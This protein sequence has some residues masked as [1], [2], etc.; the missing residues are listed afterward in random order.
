MAVVEEVDE[1]I[2]SNIGPV[3]RLKI[4][5]AAGV[6]V[7]RGV[8]GCGKS[9]TIEAVERLTGD[10]KINP[11]VRDGARKGEI[12]GCGVHVLV[13]RDKSRNHGE[14]VVESLEGKFDF[15]KVVD[16]GGIKNPAAADAYRIKSLLPLKNLTVDEALFYPV[17]GG[18]KAHYDDLAVIASDDIVEHTGRVKRAIEEKARKCEAEADRLWGQHGTR[19]AD[20]AEYGPEIERDAETLNAELERAIAT[21]A[22]MT[23]RAERYH[24][25]HVERDAAKAKLAA[26][27]PSNLAKLQANF[28]AKIEE[29]GKVRIE[30]GRLREKLAALEA[31]EESLT[32]E[33]DSALELRD[34]EKQRCNDRATFEEILAAEIQLGP[35]YEEDFAANDAL[36]AARAAV[37][38]GIKARQADRLAAAAVNI[39]AQ[40]TDYRKRAIQLRDAAKATEE[41]LSDMVAKLGVDLFV[42]E[43]R[44]AM[45][46]DRGV[47]LFADLSQGERS[48]VVMELCCKAIGAGGLIPVAQEFWEG[49]DPINK[50]VIADTARAGGVCVI[51]AEATEGELRAESFAG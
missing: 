26:L 11:D 44:L 18:T 46:T 32:A 38:L 4:P 14:L 37:E 25:Q 45:N 42:Y 9:R 16:G 20:K 31:L 50:K 1:I 43:G 6:T 35:S 41:I 10:K 36:K 30:A 49:Q 51:T 22:A 48:R 29:R 13:S 33:H 5:L 39:K 28:E 21:K 19:I 17:A 27:P 15:A 3:E 34:A 12:V 24:A 40:E 7:L 2:V 23:D 47:E 8:N